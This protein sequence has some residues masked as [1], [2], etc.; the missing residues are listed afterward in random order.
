[1]TRPGGVFEAVVVTGGAETLYRCGGRGP[2][3]AVLL[4]DRAGFFDEL[5]RAVRV[6]E[7]LR[8]PAG[9]GS[10]AWQDWLQ[11]VVDGLGLDRPALVV[12]PALAGAARRLAATD[13]ERFGA[14]VEATAPAAVRALL[15]AG[16]ESID[17]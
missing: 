5:V 15:L 4:T 12:D 14:V 3:T 10:P 2:V 13:P 16:N 9:P 8:R 6:V 11:A 7:P 1:M 17:V